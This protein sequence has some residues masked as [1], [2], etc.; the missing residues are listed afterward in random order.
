MTRSEKLAARAETTWPTLAPHHAAFVTWLDARLPEDA[1]VHDLEAGDL[2]LAFAAA[3]GDAWAIARFDEQFLAP[4]PRY[5]KHVDPSPAFADEVR[6]TV[7]T[8]LLVGDFDNGA[9]RLATYRGKG[10]LAG[11]VKVCALRAALDRVRGSRRAAAAT[12]EAGQALPTGADLELDYVRARYKDAFARSFAE[13]LRACTAE[14]RTILR[15]TYLDAVTLGELGALYQVHAS[16]MSRRIAQIRDGIRAATL[17]ALARNLGARSD[18][19]SSLVRALDSDIE[20][21]FPA[22][23]DGTIS[24]DVP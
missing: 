19:L 4:I 7:R 2:L 16:T 9:P 10:T 6:Q 1:Q 20:E 24:K 22:L 18:E 17:E 12:V 11:F 21:S 3:A 23:L 5:V 15:L 14:E 8:R 13:A